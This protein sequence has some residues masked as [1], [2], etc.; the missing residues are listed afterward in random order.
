MSV[1]IE[2]DAPQLLPQLVARL[3]A[4]GCWAAPISS[5]ACR[6]FHRQ[7]ETADV[8]MMELRFFANAWAGTLGDVGVRLRRGV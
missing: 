8:A 5:D 6:V 7:A 4:A 3:Q 1:I 2:I